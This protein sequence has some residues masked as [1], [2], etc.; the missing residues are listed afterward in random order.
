MGDNF[1]FDSILVPYNATSGAKR[2]LMAAMDLAE[3]IDGQ[4]TLITCIESSSLASF[5]RKNKKDEFEKERKIIQDE[6]ENIEYDTKKLKKPLK[7]VILKSSFAPDTIAEYAEENKIGLVVIG[8]TKIL[9][10]EEKYHERMAQY[11]LRGLS[12]PIL[13]VK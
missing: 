1:S 2:G 7:H 8:Q 10:T 13:I 9:P 11:L 4:I 6:L 5:F 3:K 12:C